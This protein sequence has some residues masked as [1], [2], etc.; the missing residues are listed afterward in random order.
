MGGSQIANNKFVITNGEVSKIIDDEYIG[1][2]EGSA[3]IVI[4]YNLYKGNLV[5]S[6]IRN[7]NGTYDNNNGTDAIER[8]TSLFKAS[9]GF[10]GATTLNSRVTAFWHR[11]KTDKVLNTKLG[12][13]KNGVRT[14]TNEDEIAEFLKLLR[15]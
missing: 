13:R 7:S 12:K 9:R 6:T 14:I 2:A 10:T 11:E 5:H 15:Q 3:L 8:G 1:T 4:F